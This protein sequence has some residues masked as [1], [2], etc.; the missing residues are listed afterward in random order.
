M[1]PDQ[2]LTFATIAEHGSISRAALALHLSQPAVSGQLRLLQD[3][4]GE[5]LYRRAGRGIEL[6][7][8]GRQLATLARQFHHT[9]ERSHRLRQALANLEHGRLALGASTTPASYVLPHLLAHFRRR[10]PGLEIQLVSGN[11]GDICRQLDQFDL[12]FIEGPVPADLAPDVA[13]RPWHRDELVVIVPPDHPLASGPGSAGNSAPLNLTQLA[14][15][16]L[17]LREPG[18]G[19]RQQVLQALHDAGIRPSIALE[20]AGVEGVKEGVRAGLG[21][22]FVSAM[23]M[24]RP[25][26]DLITLRVAHPHSLERHLSVLI[27]HAEVAS[28]AARRFT[29]ACFDASAYNAPFAVR[30]APAA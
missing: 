10:H 28:R 15:W 26:P 20:L 29:D 17:V 24:Q 7:D 22:G 4:F 27:P 18:S 2:L 16:P 21:I 19:V 30:R 12:A 11:T 3:S 1:T 5:A 14:E 9:W 13:V 6:T 8:A 23:A 25:D